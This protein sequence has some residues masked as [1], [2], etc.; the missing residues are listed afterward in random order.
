[1]RAAP[2]SKRVVVTVPPD[3]VTYIEQKASY[4]GGSISGEFVRSVRE[5]MERE[6]ADKASVE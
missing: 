1:M 2:N 4:N 3:V 6:A 5:R